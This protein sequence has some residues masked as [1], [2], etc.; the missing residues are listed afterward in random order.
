MK[1]DQTCESG[2]INVFNGGTLTFSY[3]VAPVVLL[4]GPGPA[5]LDC[6]T[7]GLTDPAT[8]RTL[9]P[10]TGGL[11]TGDIWTIGVTLD[12]P[13]VGDINDCQGKTATLGMEVT[14]TQSP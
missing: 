9:T 3:T 10:G 5:A 1:A 8:P 2:A 4:E 11:G 14:A 12:G 13:G 7:V 6:W